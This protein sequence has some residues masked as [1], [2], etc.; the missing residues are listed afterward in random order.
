M[1]IKPYGKYAKAMIFLKWLLKAKTIDQLDSPILYEFYNQ[2][3]KSKVNRTQ[4]AT[5]EQL[6]KSYLKDEQV[7]EITDHGAGSATHPS[8]R[9]SIASISGSAVSSASK[10][11]LLYK[12]CQHFDYQ[13]GLE[14]GTS[15]GI[16]ALYMKLSLIHISEPTRPY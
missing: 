10:C 4:V 12:T 16:S 7:I 15:L 1:D 6:R 8:K 5:I 13:R 9:R 3:V 14:L 2:V 11:E